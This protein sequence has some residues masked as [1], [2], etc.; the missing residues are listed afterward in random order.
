MHPLSDR[1]VLGTPY[2][3]TQCSVKTTDTTYEF[4]RCRW[5]TWVSFNNRSNMTKE[6]W[7]YVVV[8]VRELRRSREI[9]SK[10]RVDGNSRI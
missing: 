3:N 9:H 8:L 5:T 1:T 4:M 7:K 2:L 10:G 6:Y